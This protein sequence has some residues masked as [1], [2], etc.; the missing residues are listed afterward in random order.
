MVPYSCLQIAAHGVCPQR[1]DQ[2]LDCLVLGHSFV[3]G[4]QYH[5]SNKYLHERNQGLRHGLPDNCK[6]TITSMGFTVTKFGYLLYWDI[7][8]APRHIPGQALFC[9]NIGNG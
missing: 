5:F 6:L 2:K 3:H 7:T 8:G 1:L 9:V 4:L